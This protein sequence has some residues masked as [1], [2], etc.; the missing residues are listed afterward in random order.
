MSKVYCPNCGSEMLLPEK[1]SI[2]IGMTISKETKG[3]FALPLEKVRHNN[4]AKNTT[5]NN[6]ENKENKTMNNMM[7]G[8]D[9]EMLAKMVAAQLKGESVQTQT[10]VK[11]APNVD[12]TKLAN[13]DTVDRNHWAENSQ[14]YGKEICGYAYNPY[15][16]R[17]FLPAQFNQLI[18]KYGSNVHR[19]ITKEYSYMYSIT[20]TLEEVRKLAMLEKRDKIAFDERKLIF[21]LPKCKKI[22]T[23]YIN[24]VITHIKQECDTFVRCNKVGK[25]FYYSVKGF[26]WFE[27]GVIAERIENHKVVKYLEMTDSLKRVFD[28][29]NDMKTRLNRGC[30]TYKDLHKVMSAKDL[31]KVPAETTKSK[32][33]MDCFIKAG[34]YYTLKQQLMFDNS[35][36]FKGYNGRGAVIELRRY[37]E[38]GY[39]GYKIYAMYKE[40]NRI[41]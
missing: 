11:N 16:I 23:E 24:N 41:R 15:M 29:L 32:D 31:I 14:F 36:C 3:D 19:A 25:K 17:R 12:V 1:S 30:Y 21:T 35:V 8:F 7:N 20:Y 40:V 13:S 26:G 6:V 37:L 22:F 34:A 2:G 10:V 38:R 5:T 39:E 27:A 9:M 4:V 28:H 18:G 33:F